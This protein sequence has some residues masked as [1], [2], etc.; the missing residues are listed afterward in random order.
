M[1][2][3]VAR[4]PPVPHQNSLCSIRPVIKAL[5]PVYHKTPASNNAPS[6]WE[7]LIMCLIM[8]LVTGR[9]GYGPLFMAAPLLLTTREYRS[10]SPVGLIEA[11]G[12]RNSRREAGGVGAKRYRF[13]DF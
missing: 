5:F 10:P 6:G 13:R 4:S 8:C 3:C 12:V 2:L 9:S 1:P 11:P 7:R